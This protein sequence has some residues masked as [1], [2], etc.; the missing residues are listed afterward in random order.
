M[1]CLCITLSV[2]KIDYVTIFHC[3]DRWYYIIELEVTNSTGI[4]HFFLHIQCFLKRVSWHVHLDWTMNF[5]RDLHKRFSNS[6]HQGTSEGIVEESSPGNKTVIKDG[7][8][9]L[10]LSYY[11]LHS[12]NFNLPFALA[13]AIW[14]EFCGLKAIS[15]KP[16]LLLHVF[17][18]LPLLMSHKI[19][20]P[21]LLA[22]AT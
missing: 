19:I 16:L 17:K 1:R 20:F 7:R 12:I 21:L 2:A 22:V 5:V 15:T 8:I 9:K 18:R 11:G 6:F 4:Q 13:T 3:D 14:L 10:Q